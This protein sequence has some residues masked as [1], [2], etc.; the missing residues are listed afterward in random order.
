MRRSQEKSAGFIFLG[1]EIG[2]G[3]V[4]FTE[5]KYGHCYGEEVGRVKE[6]KEIILSA[7]KPDMGSYLKRENR[8]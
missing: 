4:F 2:E 3:G 1:G 8:I 7:M 6:S 5:E